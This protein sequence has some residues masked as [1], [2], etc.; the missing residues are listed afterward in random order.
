MA[1]AVV[2]G[3]KEFT[4]VFA[5][6][7]MALNTN[8]Y[9]WYL[10][11]LGLVLMFHSVRNAN[12]P[13]LAVRD[14]LLFTATW[15]LV[16][17]M[18]LKAVGVDVWILV[19]VLCVLP[20]L[21]LSVI[22]IPSTRILQALYLAAVIVFIQIISGSLP[23]GGFPWL[24]LAYGQVDGPFMFLSRIGGQELVAFVT[25]VVAVVLARQI[26]TKK[27]LALSGT[28]LII[29]IGGIIGN[30]LSKPSEPSSVNIKVG[31]VQGGLSV[32]PEQQQASD[33][34]Q[35]HLLQTSALAKTLDTSGQTIDLLVWPENALASDPRNDPGVADAIQG[36]AD[37]MNV[38][39]LIGTNTDQER[40][41]G[42]RN[43]A[44]LWKPGRGI[45][46]QYDKKHL[47][48][49]GEYIPYRQV[50]AKRIGRL[51]QI[52]QDF[53]PGQGSGTFTL[54]RAIFG[55]AICFE[56]AFA[57]H[58]TDLV[59]SGANFL[60]VQTN[61]ATYSKTW[62]PEQQFN[63]A[64]FRAIEHYRPVAVASTTGISGFI[65]SNGKVIE[66]TQEVVSDHLVESIV[67]QKGLTFS[68]RHPGW[69]KAT[70]LFV[71]TL[72]LIGQLSDW[73][74]RRRRQPQVVQSLHLVRR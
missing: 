9:G 66:Q 44:Q 6:L 12:Y 11:F 67:A 52:P 65:D 72:G 29:F 25:V 2:L 51:D 22:R 14:I 69:M 34:R 59:R 62:Q 17:L 40:G 19:S 49:F 56:V 3:R 31:V 39:I 21:F 26:Y 33:V 74:Q 32:L 13:R 4:L 53:V 8:G 48:P 30:S 28:I 60:V 18:W 35:R 64:R 36:F 10:G 41:I 58:M 54:P 1:R 37:G 55:T 45:A 70:V 50:L 15:F 71:L 7:L 73:Y 43:S 24:N 68:D 27:L 42:L 57:E 47:V 63:I 38:P 20:W 46:Q 16:S 61:N 23:W 5:G